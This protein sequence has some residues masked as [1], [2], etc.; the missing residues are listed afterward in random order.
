MTMS[1]IQKCIDQFNVVSDSQTAFF[2]L[3]FILKT[4]YYSKCMHILK[5]ME[6]LL[7]LNHVEIH[8]IYKLLNDGHPVIKKWIAFK[9]NVI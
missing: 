9:K 5:C 3:V 6:S 8:S 2:P 1:Q 4:E 7:V